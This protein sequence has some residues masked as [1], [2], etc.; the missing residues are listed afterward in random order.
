MMEDCHLTKLAVTGLLAMT[1]GAV[2]SGCAS[3]TPLAYPAA[4][5]GD[6]VDVYHGVSVADP[7]R[8]LEAAETPATRAFV[9]AQNALAQP[10]LE[11]LPQREALKTRLTQLWSYERF[12]VPRR[13]GGRYFYL[14]NDGKQ[15]Q[16]VLHVA[17][18]AGSLGRV[19]FDP[20]ATRDD[21]TIALSRFVPSPDGKLVAYA[22]SDG[23]T[24][25]ISGAS[26]ACPT[27]SICPMNCA[28]RNSGSCPGR[29][30]A[31]P[32]TTAAIQPAPR[33]APRRSRTVNPV[34]T[35]RHSPSSIA[36]DSAVSRVPTNKSMP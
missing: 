19:L 27:A 33:Q 20:N 22:L 36:T 2:L 1:S 34:A 28:S 25:W 26:G 11:A 17:D 4:P 3:T 13:E 5:R 8:W 32:C 9:E 24:D 10:W 16:S 31:R 21:A 15:N 30:T 7:Y 14:R 35:T 6:V 18:D 12:G 29:G 23:G